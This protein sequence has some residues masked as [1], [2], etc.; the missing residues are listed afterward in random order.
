MR[1]QLGAAALLNT[2]AARAETIDPGTTVVALA[3]TA[4]LWLSILVAWLGFHVARKVLPRKGPHQEDQ[5]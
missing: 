3:M 1:H 4:G 2:L 5:E